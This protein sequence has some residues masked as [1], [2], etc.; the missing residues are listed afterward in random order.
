MPHD[1]D[2][3]TVPDVPSY[4]LFLIPLS[5]FLFKCPSRALEPNAHKMVRRTEC[6]HQK[7]MPIDSTRSS[8]Q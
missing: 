4:P 8:S 5:F 2:R 6:Q 7:N 3:E 1:S